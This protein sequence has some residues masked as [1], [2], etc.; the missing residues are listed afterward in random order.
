[1]VKYLHLPLVEGFYVSFYQKEVQDLALGRTSKFM[2]PG[3]MGIYLTPWTLD[4][5]QV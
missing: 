2:E 4:F 1:M 3:T 5:N